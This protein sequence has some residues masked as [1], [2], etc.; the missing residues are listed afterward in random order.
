[1]SEEQKEKGYQQRGGNKLTVDFRSDPFYSYPTIAIGIS[2]EFRRARLSR[3][4]VRK[5]IKDLQEWI[6]DDEL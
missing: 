4:K 5:L 1:M 3:P 2:G 6:D